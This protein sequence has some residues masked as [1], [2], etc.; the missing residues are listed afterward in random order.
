MSGRSSGVEHNLAKV[1]VEGS[2]PFARSSFFCNRS[3]RHALRSA[4]AFVRMGGS[5][6]I[7]DGQVALVTGAGRGFGRAIAERFAA[8]GRGGGACWR[9]RWRSSTKSPMR[10]A[11][12]AATLSGVRCDVTDAASV[13][14]AVAKAAGAARSG[15]PAGQQR[16]R[17]GAVRADLASRSRRV[18][19]RAGDPYPRADAVHAPGAAGH[20]R[21]RPGPGDLRLGHR[22]PPGGAEPVGLLHRQDRAEPAGGRSR[23]RAGGHRGGGVRDRSRASPRPSSRAT[24]RPTPRRAST[25]SR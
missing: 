22:Q 11:R 13:E 21:A 16:G 6:G 5:M 14:H 23:G 4:I 19:A 25:S 20:G 10:S 18:V 3:Y 17:A 8:E 24:P 1:G 9:A 15:R 7:L 12:A 2:N